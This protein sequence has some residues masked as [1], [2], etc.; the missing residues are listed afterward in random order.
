MLKL[1]KTVSFS[2]LGDLHRCAFSFKLAR[3]DG[4]YLSTSSIDTIFGTL[5]HQCCQN[6][7]RYKDE[8]KEIAVFERSWKKFRGIFKNH[9]DVKAA[10]KLQVAGVNALK[11]I[12]PFVEKEYGED[13]EVLSVEEELLENLEGFEQKFKAFVDIVILSKKHERLVIADLKTCKTAYMFRK[14]AGIEKERQLVL[15]KHFY[16]KKHGIEPEDLDVAFI[17]LEKDPNSK[18]PVQMHKITSGSVKVTNHLKF[19]DKSLTDL[20]CLEIF[21]KNRLGCRFCPFKASGH[22]VDP[23]T[24]RWS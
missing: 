8:L 19:V 4:I 9:I 1:P 3:I 23:N 16:C 22:C 7:L 24:T 15:Y 17:L 6:I 18:N 14:N 13:Y 20:N 12:R 11:L 2:S 10:E 5:V 21:P